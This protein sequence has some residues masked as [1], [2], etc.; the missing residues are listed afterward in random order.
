MWFS[1]FC[2]VFFFLSEFLSLFL[3]FFLPLFLTDDISSF[4]ASAQ[5]LSSAR[6]NIQAIAGTQ[7]GFVSIADGDV[8]VWIGGGSTNPSNRDSSSNTDRDQNCDTFL[9]N[10]GVPLSMTVAGSGFP[11]GYCI[12]PGG[13][14]F[15]IA[16]GGTTA[17]QV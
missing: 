1:F 17:G 13:D 12:A 2:S 14:R 7:S 9:A 4:G 5:S 10:N 16:G 11:W 3:S 15:R 8:R 6:F